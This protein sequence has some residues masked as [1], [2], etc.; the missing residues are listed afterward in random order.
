M[1]DVVEEEEEDEGQNQVYSDAAAS[2]V[3]EGFVIKATGKGE[4]LSMINELQH[5]YFTWKIDN[6]TD[7]KDEDYCSEQFTVEG[8]RWKLK[9][10]PKGSRTG[11]GTWLSLYLSLDDSETLPPNRKLYAKYKLRIRD[12]INSNHLEET[13]LCS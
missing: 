4:C 11:S 5:N 13:S 8:R 7:L 1:A 2:L 3:V 9:L 12:Q 10:Y 6:F